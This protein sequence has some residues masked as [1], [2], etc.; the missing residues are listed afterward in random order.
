MIL[1][2]LSLF[3]FGQLIS[4]PVALGSIAHLARDGRAMAVGLYVS[5]YYLGGSVGGVLP[6]WTWSHYGWPGCFAL[7][8]AVEISVAALAAAAWRM[9]G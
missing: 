1:V 2:G 8:V 6:A 3:S 9:R 5:S 7:V 4:Q